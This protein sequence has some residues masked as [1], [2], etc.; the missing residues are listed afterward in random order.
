MFSQQL[1][2]FWIML[3]CLII[4][5]N[6]RSQCT[7]Q[8]SLAFDILPDINGRE[9]LDIFGLFI[10]VLT[11]ALCFSESVPKFF[12]PSSYNVSAFC[13]AYQFNVSAV[14]HLKRGMGKD[15]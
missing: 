1:S 2:L 12:S 15:D 5:L 9:H 7:E 14:C 6:M 10:E 4:F 11:A 3:I 8:L 13:P